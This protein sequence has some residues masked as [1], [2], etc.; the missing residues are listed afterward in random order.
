MSIVYK[1]PTLYIIGWLYFENGMLYSKPLFPSD[2]EQLA[3][4]LSNQLFGTEGIDLEPHGFFRPRED[5]K[6]LSF[7]LRSR[8]NGT[9][10]DP[11]A[12]CIR[13]V[14]F[15]FKNHRFILSLE[16]EK[17]DSWREGVLKI[18]DTIFN[19]FFSPV[20]LNGFFKGQGFQPKYI[21]THCLLVSPN[22]SPGFDT[23]DSV[24]SQRN[25]SFG[26]YIREYRPN[27]R[28][29]ELPYSIA[30]RRHYIQLGTSYSQLLLDG[31]TLGVEVLDDVLDAI[32]VGGLQQ[33]VK[34]DWSRSNPAVVDKSAGNNTDRIL[35]REDGALLH[36]NH[37]K[38]TNDWTN[39]LIGSVFD[40]LQKFA[41]AHSAEHI[42]RALAVGGIIVSF[43]VVFLRKT[44]EELYPCSLVVGVGAGL[45]C[46]GAAFI[47]RKA[48]RIWIRLLVIV[49]AHLYLGVM[50]SSDHV[51]DLNCWPFS[52]GQPSIEVPSNI[53][54]ATNTNHT[55]IFQNSRDKLEAGEQKRRKKKRLHS[56]QASP[57]RPTVPPYV[58]LDS[59]RGKPPNSLPDSSKL[60]IRESTLTSPGVSRDTCP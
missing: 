18:H 43:Y 35:K 55:Y 39:D 14:N 56:K 52:N 57:S 48:C 34:G 38:Q 19:R 42:R 22:R 50:W 60:L 15:G 11:F 24:Y 30:F 45:L 21:Y 44:I 8:L 2:M 17:K 1:T 29:E 46:L 5:E 26:H 16:L 41:Q 23:V 58:A 20:A 54:E 7:C 53:G 37:F 32:V 40:L 31:K 4:T 3:K 6:V 28:P 13:N 49:A 10:A 36:E 27:W 33:N 59:T 12:N 25:T 47:P 9:D 51:G